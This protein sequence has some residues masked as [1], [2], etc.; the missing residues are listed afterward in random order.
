MTHGNAIVKK[1]GTAGSPWIITKVASRVK[2]IFVFNFLALFAFSF[3]QPQFIIASLVKKDSCLFFPPTVSLL[4]CFFVSRR[5]QPKAS[6]VS[7]ERL[8]TF[9]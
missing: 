8:L 4:R 7:I 2:N 9:E 5:S 6:S 1:R 3:E